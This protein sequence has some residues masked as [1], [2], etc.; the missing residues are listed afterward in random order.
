[1]RDLTLTLSRDMTAR[2][3]TVWRCMTEAEL[4]KRWFAPE[5]VTVTKAVIDPT[6]GSTFHV[7]MHI[8]DMGEMDGGAGCVLEAQAARRLTWTTA[9]LPGFGPGPAPA[10]GA[11]HFTAIL[12]LAPLQDGGTRYTATVLHAD[13]AGRAA[14]AA[15]G[16]A[17]GWGS[18]AKQLD[19]LSRSI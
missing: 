8:P 4:L 11:F 6:P 17:D 2:P 3:E 19:T 1:M 16:F 18:M 15:M 5:P 9:L 14:H 13:E 10:E 12:A 7:V